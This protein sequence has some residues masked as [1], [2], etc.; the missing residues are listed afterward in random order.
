VEAAPREH[1]SAAAAEA[2]RAWQ[3]VVA[4]AAL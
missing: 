3:A 2:A 1:R 4:A